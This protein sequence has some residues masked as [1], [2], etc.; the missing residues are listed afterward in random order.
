MTRAFCWPGYAS[1]LCMH[2]CNLTTTLGCSFKN[3]PSIQ[4]FWRHSKYF[5]VQ[6]NKRSYNLFWIKVHQRH[7]LAADPPSPSCVAA[8][9]G[10]E[11]GQLQALLVLAAPGDDIPITVS[12]EQV[13]TVAGKRKA[14]KQQKRLF[15]YQMWL[16][17]VLE[18]I[19]S[20]WEFSQQRSAVRAG[21]EPTLTQQ[22]LHVPAHPFV[23]KLA[24]PQLWPGLQHPLQFNTH[25]FA[26]SEKRAGSGAKSYPLSLLFLKGRIF[27]NRAQC[28]LNLLCWQRQKLN[29]SDFMAQHRTFVQM[30]ISWAITGLVKPFCHAMGN[31]REHEGQHPFSVTFK[32]ET[33]N[34]SIATKLLS[35]SFVKYAAQRK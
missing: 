8:E 19:K 18:D 24:E 15:L 27:Y 12:R 6:L 5:E 17:I 2:I 35:T 7:E 34:Y 9:E 26:V 32:Q 23:P 4:S 21:P 10:V 30:G 3:T 33:L 29:P 20:P 28:P 11:H 31:V 13:M 16:F 14:A 1:S 25:F 22:C